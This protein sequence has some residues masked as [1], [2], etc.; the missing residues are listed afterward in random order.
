MVVLSHDTFKMIPYRNRNLFIIANVA[1]R[2][3]FYLIVISRIIK[4]KKKA[5]VVIEY[6]VRDS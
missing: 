1:Y 6:M 3:Y 4:K 5:L 2:F